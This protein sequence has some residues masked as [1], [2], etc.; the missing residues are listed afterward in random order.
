MINCP[1]PKYGTRR[2]PANP[3]F[4]ARV[5][6]VAEY[7]GTPL[8]PWQRMVADVIMELNPSD[9]GAWRYQQVVISVP[10]QAG[11]TALLRAVMTDRM[12]NY[13]AHTILMTAQTGK[14]AR[15][16]W[17]QLL[18][19]LRAEKKPDIFKT[20]LSQGS[21]AV[22]FIPNA[23]AISPFAPTPKSIHGDSLHLVTVD[24][25]W[26][27][28]AEKGA[29]LET[30][31]NPTQLTVRDSQLII[32]STKGT[33]SSAYLNQLIEKGREAVSDPLS[34]MAF[35]EWSADEKKAEE[36]PY[37]DDTLAFHP[38]IG[39]TQSADKIRSLETAS[40]DAWKRSIL[41]LETSTES[42]ILNLAV[43]DSLSTNLTVPDS[44]ANISLGFDVA[45]NREASTIYA[46]WT[47]P[48]KG[49][50]IALVKQAPGASWLLQDIPALSRLGYRD[51]IADDS[52]TTRTLIGDLDTETRD[53]ISVLRPREYA[54]ACQLFLDRV[55]S[56]ELQHDH[57]PSLRDAIAAAVLRSMGG[58][59]AFDPRKSA[60]AIDALRAATCAI[61]GTRLEEPAP[62][63][64][65]F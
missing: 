49:L 41:N 65:Y 40:L 59:V 58:A 24:E 9:P 6:A 42:T 46:A 60:G 1:P 25:A 52:G 12:M 43:W 7:L 34:S 20:R 47:H 45:Q 11:K 21:E 22:T 14:D 32:V 63:A 10:R 17:K 26:S 31:I 50:Q 54:T 55:K 38:A 3:T 27:F 57:N 28:D 53:K 29:A 37:S 61:W 19:T 48:E 4:G 5:A 15:K 13:G 23:S 2:N 62:L 36:N 39:H 51:I 16:R 18:Y 30:A 64:I 8:M 33:A 35:F 56:G 44:P